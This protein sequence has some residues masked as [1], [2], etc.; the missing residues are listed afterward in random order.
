MTWN[1]EQCASCSLFETLRHQCIPRHGSFGDADADFNLYAVALR[2]LV[3]Q[4]EVATHEHLT[5]RQNYAIGIAPQEHETML[6]KGL[7]PLV[8]QS[9]SFFSL[10]SRVSTHAQVLGAHFDSSIVRKWLAFCRR[11][12]F[13]CRYDHLHAT[14]YTPTRLINC[15]SHKTYRPNKA[16]E[17]IALSY[18]CGSRG[19]SSVELSESG[20]IMKAP[21]VVYDAMQ[22]V[23]S[24]DIVYLWVDQICINQND[25]HE[26]AH[27]INNM[28]R[29]YSG[30]LLTM[31]A[32][33]GD[34]AHYGLRGTARTPRRPPSRMAVDGL[35]LHI[36][37]ADPLQASEN[38]VWTTR[39]WTYQ[40]KVLSTR[41]LYFT[42]H[43]VYFECRKHR[44]REAID[45][46]EAYLADSTGPGRDLMS[47]SHLR[48]FS[49]WGEPPKS[50]YHHIEMYSKRRLTQDSDAL[51]AFRG[52]LSFYETLEEPWYHIWGMLLGGQLMAGRCRDDHVEASH[53][54]PL[55]Y[56]ARSLM[57]T[58]TNETTPEVNSSFPSWSWLGWTSTKSMQLC[59]FQPKGESSNV[60]QSAAIENHSGDLLHLIDSQGVSLTGEN[61]ALL[62]KVL[63]LEAPI[64]ASLTL[65]AMQKTNYPAILELEIE[66]QELFHGTVCE[67]CSDT[68]IFDCLRSCKLAGIVLGAGYY[69]DSTT[70]GETIRRQLRI[71]LVE[72]V[73]PT[74]WRRA[75]FVVAAISD[76]SAFRALKWNV[77]NIRI[78]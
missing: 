66:G 33:A 54:S 36:I 1:P 34:D 62:T 55:K 27:E 7:L 30:A 57:W 39:G 49:S 11:R 16:A 50:W 17:Y 4:D 32:A 68:G 47:N 15:W 38:S 77:K 28:H 35:S 56:L 43:E 71:L 6:S 41:R 29:I 78:A 10:Q 61:A 37:P 52:I 21:E 42:E 13:A 44:Y 76:E 73:E 59:A 48:E 74:L 3:S 14:E 25:E 46:P 75:G 40:E 12:H 58:H 9:L 2:A 72:Q 19:A 70:K 53:C 24:L 60:L 26:K 5:G 31:V 20:T 65:Q 23:K 18:V 69:F 67:S 64:I 45:E 51:P 63:H 22:V 8:A